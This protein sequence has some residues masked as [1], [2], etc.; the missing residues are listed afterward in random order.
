MGTPWEHDENIVRTDP[1]NPPLIQKN[2]KEKIPFPPSHCLHEIS[3]YRTVK[4]ILN[5]D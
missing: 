2:P 4:T 5:L 3:V 1:K